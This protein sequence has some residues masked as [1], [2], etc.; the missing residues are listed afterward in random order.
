MDGT[1]RQSLS[2]L[3]RFTF[4]LWRADF[5]ALVVVGFI[6]SAAAVLEV[7]LVRVLESQF[8]SS[9]TALGFVLYDGSHVR[10]SWPLVA[11]GLITAAATSSWASSTIV[12]MLLGHV[13]QG[14][15]ASVRDLGCGLRY[16]PWV[17]GVVLAEDLVDRG[18][19]LAGLFSP[20]LTPLSGL[21]QFVVSI[22]FMTVFVFF[23]QEIVGRGSTASAAL[24]AS[25]ILARSTG[26]WRVFGNQVLLMCCL[27][28][29]LLVDVA[30]IVHFGTAGSLS[31]QLLTGV[32][33]TPL[34]L[35]F[36]TIM[37]LL[38]RGDRGQ[39]EGALGS[40]RQAGDGSPLVEGDAVRPG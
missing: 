33:A 9:G 24:A 38:A 37:Y 4:R 29:V 5:V 12:A 40:V 21:V 26:V 7:V 6:A 25:S 28:P 14:R 8:P 13:G 20:I 19:H 34:I 22:A 15:R 31:V 1:D 35:A 2:G 32:I 23:V 10:I 3:F 11:A 36:T 17:F 27:L 39:V 30:L 16:W 18:A